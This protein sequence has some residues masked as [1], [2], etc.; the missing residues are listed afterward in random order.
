MDRPVRLAGGAEV[1]ALIADL[2][3]EARPSH[4]QLGTISLR[5]HQIEAVARLKRSLDEFGGAFLCDDV[6][7]GKTF[8]AA[9]IAGEYNSVLIVAPAALREMW[10]DAL[11][12][13]ALHADICTFERLSRGTLDGRYD[14]IVVDEAHHVRNPATKRY[15]SL[16]SM[17][18][19]TKVLLLSATPIHNREKDLRALLRLFLGRRA[20]QLTADELSRCVVRRADGGAR[21]EAGIPRI[22]PTVMLEFGGSPGLVADLLAFPPP[23]PVRDGGVARA[24]I[25]RGLVHQWASSEA[26]LRDAIRRRRARGYALR[27]SLQA[28]ALPTAR[29]LSTWVFEDDALQLGFAEL[30]AEP[31]GEP[32][33]LLTQLDA[34]LT[35]LEQF[36]S[37]HAD[38]FVL[39]ERRADLIAAIVARHAAS[40]I[41]AFAQYE[42]TV[43]AMFE[44]LHG[45][46]RTALL[47]A[48]GARIASGRISRK[49]VLRQFA[50]DADGVHS[51]DRVDLLL[52][53][54]ILS[55]GVNLQSA[56]VVIHLDTPWT[57]ARL[58]QRVGRVAR[59][60][61][62]HDV[63]SVYALRSPLSA[64]TALEMEDIVVAKWRAAQAAVGSAAR[65]PFAVETNNESVSIPEL[66]EQLQGLVR[67]WSDGGTLR[68]CG[69]ELLVTSVKARSSGFFAALDENGGSVLIA[70][71]DSTISIALDRIVDAAKACTTREVPVDPGS[72]NAALSRIANWS[73]ARSTRTMLGIH[74]SSEVVHRPR[75]TSQIGSMIASSPLHLRATRSSQAEQVLDVVSRQHSASVEAL[76]EEITSSDAPPDVWLNR[77][78]RLSR[79]TPRREMP[80]RRSTQPI[81]RALI[82]FER[83]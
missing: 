78:R 26:A 6:G 79:A 74:E 47:T 48:K 20:D 19:T 33:M 12:R 2:F 64:R 5:P 4:V 44:R 76:L 9:A 61:S 54:D 27:A 59:M 15:R 1:R 3:L 21:S 77:V 65:H 73:S 18:G 71:N 66:S 68:T 75:I 40:R 46:I 60:G 31:V 83:E 49:E 51:A 7:M 52:T 45:R 10:T 56:D 80:S 81:L 72:L 30:L 17:I 50:D 22:A 23:L 11:A 55:E 35:A 58:E 42:Q 82:L 70:A 69:D 43:D 36:E 57:A 25:V 39:D 28:G 38:D 63:V 24:L 32:G 8:V 53:T 29:E 16:A 41:I 37:K 14:C 67:T 13:T 34:H 62:R